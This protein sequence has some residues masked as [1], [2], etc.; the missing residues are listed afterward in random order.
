MIRKDLLKM[1]KVK[2]C[3]KR[4]KYFICISTGFSPLMTPRKE[5]GGKNLRIPVSKT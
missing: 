4:T 3:T 1:Y 2:S 5:V